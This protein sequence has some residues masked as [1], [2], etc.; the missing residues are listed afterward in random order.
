MFVR[1][2]WNGGSLALRDRSF[3]IEFGTEPQTRRTAVRSFL[4][5]RLI[6]LIKVRKNS[7]LELKLAQERKSLAVYVYAIKMQKSTKTCFAEILEGIRMHD[8]VM[9]L[10][11]KGSNHSK[12]GR[13]FGTWKCGVCGFM[14]RI[15]HTG[16][17]EGR[18]SGSQREPTE[19]C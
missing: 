5:I 10:V 18:R 3:K 1:L 6:P 14:D 13:M 11:A 9:A 8:R 7:A 15:C 4:R 12:N 17:C 16:D 19:S 2:G